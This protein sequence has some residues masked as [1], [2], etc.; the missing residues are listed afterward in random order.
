MWRCS[1]Y[2]SI[3]LTSVIVLISHP[4]FISLYSTHKT[5]EILK[6]QAI[7][8]SCH[9]SPPVSV[10]VSALL[11]LVVKSTREFLTAI[12]TVSPL[13]RHYQEKWPP[14]SSARD[15]AQT[16]LSLCLA[17]SRGSTHDSLLFPQSEIATACALCVWGGGRHNAHAQ[18]RALRIVYM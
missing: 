4:T 16:F 9:W 14:L 11:F 15:S 2:D 3:S 17:L 13:L 10:S 12:S 1:S 18:C 8:S 6:Y 5:H 7:V